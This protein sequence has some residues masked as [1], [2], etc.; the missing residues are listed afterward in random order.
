[1]EYRYPL[2][3]RQVCI[4]GSQEEIVGLQFR[5]FTCTYKKARYHVDGGTNENQEHCYSM[6]QT[7]PVRQALIIAPLASSGEIG[8]IKPISG[9]FG[10]NRLSASRC[11]FCISAVA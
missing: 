2:Y 3:A 7:A 4:Y 6:V 1:M 8:E 9:L 11:L 10:S 5:S